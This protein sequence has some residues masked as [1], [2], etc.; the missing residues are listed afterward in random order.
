MQSKAGAAPKSGSRE[1]RERRKRLARML[2]LSTWSQVQ[3]VL[4]EDVLPEIKVPMSST[5][6]RRAIRNLNSELS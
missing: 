4:E 5:D 6:I 1:R 3:R 2:G